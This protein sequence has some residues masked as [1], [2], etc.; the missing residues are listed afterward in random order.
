M[1]N[2]IGLILGSSGDM[3]TPVVGFASTYHKSKSTILTIAATTTNTI[4][5]DHFYFPAWFG[6]ATEFFWIFSR[7]N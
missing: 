3:S 5:N 4:K 7:Q 6:T 1:G 2:F